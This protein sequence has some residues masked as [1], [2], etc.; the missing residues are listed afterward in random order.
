MPQLVCRISWRKGLPLGISVSPRVG[1]LNL[2]RELRDNVYRYS[3]I[4]SDPIT[5]WSGTRKDEDDLIY[6]TGKLTQRFCTTV[7]THC[8]ILGDLA[9]SLLLCN[10]QVSREALAILYLCN[11]FRFMGDNNWNPL[12]VFLRMIG[13]ENRG[14]LRGLEMQIPQPRHV[15]QHPD[16]TRTSMHDWR[17]CEVIVQGAYAQSSS[18]PVVGNVKRVDH[19]DP[20]IEACFRI[21]GESR[22]P[23]SLVLVLD[24]HYLPGVQ[25]MDDEQHEYAY[26]FSLD[27]PLMIEKCRQHFTADHGAISQVEVLW[28]GECVRDRFTKQTELIQDKGWMIVET[29]EGYIHHERYPLDTMLF[30]LRRKETSLAP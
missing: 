23:I 17:F 30:T 16:G 12:Y 14:N 18:P 24:R 11:T 13:D 1:F 27:M 5:V 21:L 19:L 29:K 10:K 26:C 15:W 28:K 20:A 22:P 25:V 3:L 8:P 9:L 7:D 4:N 6:S 2:P